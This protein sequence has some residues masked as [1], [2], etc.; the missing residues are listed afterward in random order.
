MYSRKDVLCLHERF[1]L[2]VARAPDA[3]AVEFSGARLTY[4]ELSRRSNAVAAQL[5]SVVTVPGQLV[6][7]SMG[8]SLELIVGLLGILKAGGAYVPI[9]PSYPSERIRLL[10]DDSGVTAV[11]SRQAEGACLPGNH[12]K[13]FVDAADASDGASP[14][15]VVCSPS[16]AAYVIYTSG[17]TGSPKGTV[18]EHRSATRLFDSTQEWFAFGPS[19]VWTMFHSISFDFSVWEIWGALL[20]G[21]RVVI[22]PSE[23]AA[24][25]VAFAQLVAAAGVTVLNQTPSAFGQFSRASIAGKHSY[26]SLRA[27][28]FGGERLDA[29]RLGPW[30]G[31][32]GDARPKL[33]NMY[34]ITETTVHVTYRPMTAADLAYPERN[35]IGRPIPDLE[36]HLLDERGVAPPPGA[37]GEIVVTGPGVARGYWGRPE[38]TAARFPMLPLGPGGALVRSYRSGDLAA[39]VDGE[40]MYLG[41]SDEQVKVRGYR[42]E[43]REIEIRLETCPEVEA[44]VVLARDFGEGDARLVAFVVTRSGSSCVAAKVSA[45]AARMLPAYM[46]P[47]RVIEV[48][49][50]PQTA[51]GKRDKD[52]LWRR[53]E[54]SALGSDVG[55]TLRV[56]DQRAAVGSTAK[57]AEIA[58]AILQADV[59]LEDDLF[60][61]GAT[62]LS[63]VRILLEVNVAF[64]LTLTGAELDADS[65]VVNIGRVVDNM[66]IGNAAKAAEF[67]QLVV[68]DVQ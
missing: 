62:S 57:V 4:R 38:L 14:A 8:R 10:L 19:D 24:A 52:A 15:G 43:L 51:H 41:R 65:S 21:G 59:S 27:V 46:C 5:A 3:V 30:I 37:P 61:Q 9:D 26:P 2:Q 29:A 58:R 31:H 20:Y 39:R 32:Y 55:G 42:I 28:I 33:I 35:P 11:V 34:G 25:P 48:D 18:V 45:F 60:D 6:G 23:V 49:D 40:L 66:L 13:V 7:L 17:S 50:I 53:F 64:A 36:V 44:C 54:A 47:S 63:L 12:V 22:V 68:G 1:E 16:D 56:E 67:G